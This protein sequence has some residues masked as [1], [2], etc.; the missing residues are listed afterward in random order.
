[1]IWRDFPDL[2]SKVEETAALIKKENE[3][4]HAEIYE[5]KKGGVK[6]YELQEAF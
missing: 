4:D 1:V 5:I 3:N 2:R 6:K